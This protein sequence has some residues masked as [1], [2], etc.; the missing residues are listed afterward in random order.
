MAKIK[1]EMH[2]DNQVARIILN[3]PKGNVLDSEMMTDISSALNSISNQN[4]IKL[5]QFMGAGNHFSFGASV[6]EHTKEN[7]S[8]MLEQ[9]HG[10]FKQIIDLGIPTAALVSGQCLGGGFELALICNYL[11][12]DI[13]AKCGQPEILLGVFAPP[14]SL[15]LPLKIGQSMADDLLLTGKVLSSQTLM[16][17]GLAHQEF[18]NQI[19][20]IN[21]VNDWVEKNILLKSASSLKYAVKAARY[22]FNKNL[23]FALDDLK[24]IYTTELMESYDANEGI[25]SF[26]EKRKPI[27]ENR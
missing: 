10:L 14:A 23:K 27:W 13:T 16:L 7:A 11:F 15:I 24:K 3:S 25:T 19:E 2:Y 17:L 12:V 22:N 9:F 21:G 20:L 1:L 26:L 6:A 5:I 4:D 8:K 18:E